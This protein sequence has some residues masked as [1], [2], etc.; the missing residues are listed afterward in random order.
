MYKI[1]LDIWNIIFDLLDFKSKM[2]LISTCKYLRQNLH[3]IDLCNIDRKYLYKLTT[4][5]LRY[6]IFKNVSYIDLSL[7]HNKIKNISFMKNLKKVIACNY[8][9]TSANYGIKQ[10]SIRD[11]DLIEFK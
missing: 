5:I 9:N 10:R 3:I 1:P 2:N 6:K 11:L 7:A 8:D 4:N